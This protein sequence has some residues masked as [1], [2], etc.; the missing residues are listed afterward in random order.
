MFDAA[1]EQQADKEWRSQIAKKGSELVWAKLNEKLVLK[2][3][4]RHAFKMAEIDRLNREHSA[5][6]MGRE[7]Q[8]H[9]NTIEKC[10]RRVTWKHV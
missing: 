1:A 4:E 8:V 10:L 7:F 3:R 2:I 9:T 6:A 5:E